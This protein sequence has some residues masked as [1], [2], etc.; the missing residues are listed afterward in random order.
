[1]AKTGRPAR[2]KRAAKVIEDNE[3]LKAYLSGKPYSALAKEFGIST[4][5]AHDKVQR[6]IDAQRPHADFDRYRAIQLG[7]LEL[8]RRPLRQTIIAWQP[9]DDLVNCGAA[10]DRLLK[11]QEREAK[12]L[13]LDR[14]PSPFDN[15]A[16]MS[17]E[18]LEARVKEWAD[19]L[20][21]DV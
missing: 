15:I 2:G 11:L 13:G 6:A 19:A 5:T 18:Q 21:Q 14:V 8:M 4:S 16:A 17:D 7:E 1:M 12:L 10:I 20:S 3:V 9:G